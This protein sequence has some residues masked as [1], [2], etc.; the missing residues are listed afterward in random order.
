MKQTASADASTGK[1]EKNTDPKEEILSEASDDFF[2]GQDDREGF[3]DW[4]SDTYGAETL[5]S[6]VNNGVLDDPEVWK[7]CTGRTI[8]TL[9]WDYHTSQNDSFSKENKVKEI[10]TKD[11]DKA[12]FLF[13][14]D[15]TLA[16]NTATTVLMDKNPNSLSQCFDQGLMD[17]MRDADFFTINNEF[18]Y[19]SAST[20]NKLPGKAFCFRA[21]PK[22]A[23]LL[24][25]IGVDLVSLANNHVYDFGKDAFLSTLS[26]L[27]KNE[28]PYI[29][30]GKNLND[31]KKAYY[32][33]ANG[34]T[35]AIIAG[36]QIER[37][38][39]YTRAATADSPGVLKCL[40]PKE[41]VDA[42]KTAEK[43]ADDVIA[44]C[45]WGTEGTHYYGGD[46]TALAKKFIKAGADAVIGG[47]THT[48]QAVEYIDKVPVFYSLGNFY[49]SSTMNMPRAYDTGL[50]RITIDSDGKLTEKF[51]PCHFSGGKTSKLKK[52]SSGYRQ[53]INDMNSWSSTAVIEKNGVIKRK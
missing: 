8:K 19:A 3:L 46:Q 16:E 1:A 47:H 44:I 40:D 26:T 52:N 48:L 9:F 10:E 32:V 20:G 27:K 5:Q 25:R 51:I 42:I 49:F 28:V 23:K 31:A 24:T 11:S 35:T 36:T 37:S 22:R 21:D 18:C 2:A 41:Y 33:I 14:G 38:T 7:N 4:F 17:T 45:H 30:A 53:I 50:A 15:L 43:N 6:M 29:G 12:D 39:N 13:S 34:R